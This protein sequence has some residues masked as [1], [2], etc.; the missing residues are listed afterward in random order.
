MIKIWTFIKDFFA[1]LGFIASIVFGFY[2]TDRIRKRVKK[3]ILPKRKDHYKQ[4]K[5]ALEIKKKEI[6]GMTPAEKIKYFEEL[7]KRTP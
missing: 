5:E 2:I 3:H 4:Y 6:K 1:T 7:K